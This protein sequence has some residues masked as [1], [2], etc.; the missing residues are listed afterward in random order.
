MFRSV[1]FLLDMRLRGRAAVVGMILLGTLVLSL[2]V[3]LIAGNGRVE[4]ILYFP[5]E[6]GPGLIAEP[7]FLTRHRSTEDNIAELVEGLLLGPSLHSAARLFPRGGSVRAAMLRGHTLY[8]DLNSR[9][10]AQ[11]PDVPLS[12]SD[13]VDILRRSIRFNFPRVHEIVLY[14]DGQV[15]A[16]PAREKNLTKHSPV[17]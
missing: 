6:H 12:A 5:R 11:Q 3:F 1:R 16:F 17:L 2:P 14:L 10:L 13:A 9:V 4:R 15:P 7:R 8:L